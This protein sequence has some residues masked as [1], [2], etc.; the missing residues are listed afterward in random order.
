MFCK[1]CGKLVQWILDKDLDD[2][3]L[4]IKARTIKPNEKATRK[5]TRN[6]NITIIKCGNCGCQLHNSRVPVVGQFDLIDAVYCPKCG[7]EFL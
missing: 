7:R 4:Q 3:Y 5:V 6:G 2:V 1:E